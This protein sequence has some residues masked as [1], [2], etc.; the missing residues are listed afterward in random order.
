[1]NMDTFINNLKEVVSPEMIIY[2]GIALL[3]LIVISMMIRHLRIRKIR[4]ELDKFENKYA[5]FKGIPL[6]FKL[7][8]ATALSKVNKMIAEHIGEYQ[9]KFDE[10]QEYLKEFSV[11]LAEL[12]DFVYSKKIKKSNQKIEELIP[13]VEKCGVA[14]HEV[15]G[16]FDEVL[17]QENMQRTNINVLKN[18]FRE[19]KKILLNNRGAYRQS[20]ET[21]DEK[22][23]QIENMFSIFEEW[24]FA[25]EF[26]K[27]SDKQ[28][29]IR[30]AMEE[31]KNLL[32]VLPAMYEKS[33]IVIP[34][35]EEQI[36]LI[37]TQAMQRG[38]YLTHLD[39]KKNLEV[40]SDI[41]SDVL[42][43]LCECKLD[44]VDTMLADC[45]VRL[46]QLE[47]LILKE[48]SSFEIVSE[49]MNVLF[50]RI[51][52]LNVNVQNI[53]DVYTR[54]NERF[55]FEHLGGRLVEVDADLDALNNHRLSL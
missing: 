5:E 45:E 28:E 51:K 41:V 55:G 54:V 29:E 18:S 21:L 15:D 46:Q 37:Y 20:V 35:R 6:S 43:K 7:N 17:E 24:M 38:V 34:N 23:T 27:A 40:I 48:E 12:D 2:A 19:Y 4:E 8:K 52:D 47:D 13:V 25:S 39:V 11:L 1:M 50:A 3:A 16:L 14:I 49:K 30:A 22:I 44:N 53:K 32:D 42:A 33:T 31:L 9:Q 26:N 36:A 10:T